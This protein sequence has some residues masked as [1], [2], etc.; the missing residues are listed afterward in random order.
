MRIHLDIERPDARSQ[1]QGGM[2]MLEVDVD[3]TRADESAGCF[4]WELGSVTVV[5]AHDGESEIAY[6]DV[7]TLTEREERL[8]CERCEDVIAM[9]NED[10]ELRARGC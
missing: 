2:L 4:G 1:L 8:A 7:V 10:A 6:D 5:S 9:Q 3:V